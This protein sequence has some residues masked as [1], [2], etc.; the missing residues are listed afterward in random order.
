MN[1]FVSGVGSSSVTV[2]A[3][4]SDVKITVT[5]GVCIGVSNLFTVTNAPTPTPEPTPLSTPTP[6]SKSTSNPKPT[7]TPKA[8]PTPSPSPTPLETTVKAKTDNGTTVDLTIRGN[9]TSLQM[10]NVTIAT[11]QSTISTTLSFTLTGESG[12]TGF[13]NMTIPKTAIVYGVKPVVF[14]EDQQAINQGYTQDPENF[15][16][17][18][19]TQ[20]STHQV[21]I[22][23]AGPL[24]SQAGSFE[25]VFAIG[26][27]VPEIVLIYIVIAVKRLRRRPEDT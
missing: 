5:E 25:P 26:L 13:S 4:G 22:Q 12:T 23:F 20:F 9:V 7:S 1:A 27:I 10:S 6:T 15:Y 19:T 18:Y 24:A 11:I 3:P 17:W 21:K 14:I 16:V 2:S 8:T